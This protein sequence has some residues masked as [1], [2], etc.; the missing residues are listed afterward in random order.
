MIEIDHTLLSEEALENLMIDIITRQSTDYGEYET[1]IQVKIKQLKQKLLSGDAI[2]VYS[3]AEEACNI[4]R[5][6]D[7]IY[8]HLVPDNNEYEASK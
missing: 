7:L 1:E 8:T 3:S 6:E 4:I 2:I 5:K